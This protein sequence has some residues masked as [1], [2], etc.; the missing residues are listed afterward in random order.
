MPDNKELEYIWSKLDDMEKANRKAS[1]TVSDSLNGLSVNV[2]CLDKTVAL[3]SQQFQNHEKDH[4][5]PLIRHEKDH[6][7][8]G[9]LLRTISTILGMVIL[10]GGLVVGVVVGVFEFLV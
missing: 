8:S 10:G 1:D 7:K 9:S 5:A 2:S 3:V 4:D 6:E